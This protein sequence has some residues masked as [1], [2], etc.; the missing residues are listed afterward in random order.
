MDSERLSQL[1]TPSTV[2]QS[3]A[4]H[5][6]L[7]DSCDV[8][9]QR[10]SRE[11][12]IELTIEGRKILTARLRDGRLVFKDPLTG[13]VSLS[14]PPL[15]SVRK[16]E[17]AVPEGFLERKDG[18]GT[19]YFFNTINSKSQYSRPTLSASEV[20]ANMARV[21]PVSHPVE[22]YFDAD[23]KPFYHNVETDK[24]SWSPPSCTPKTKSPSDKPAK[25]S[26]IST[27]NQP[28]KNP[29]VHPTVSVAEGVLLD[30]QVLPNGWE[31]HYTD[32]GHPFYF[33]P[34]SGESVW[35]LPQEASPWNPETTE[36]TFTASSSF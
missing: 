31:V 8:D 22:A 21:K 5:P 30:N 4:S 2:A 1:D 27:Q 29:E 34:V 28:A 6:V 15:L 19:S 32:D 36:K 11:S 24:V 17:T 14:V 23:G 16:V 7:S 33:D 13:I 12:V 35:E 25:Q 10:F 20:A 26:S 3:P 18:Q 9:K